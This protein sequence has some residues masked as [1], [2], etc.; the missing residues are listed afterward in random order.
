VEVTY[1]L[2]EIS[3]LAEL[4]VSTYATQKLF[5]LE[6]E[7]GAGKTTF[8]KQLCDK[9]GVVDNVSSPTYSVINKYL[10][11]DN[12]YIYHLD[13]FRL[14]NSQELINI[15]FEDILY[16]NSIILIEWPQLAYPLLD[17]ISYVKIFIEKTS[18]NSRKMITFIC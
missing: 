8:I 12:R 7:M 10:C 13:L 11:S 18:E 9:W 16:E 17:D 3:S 1:Q 5:C 15:G 4:F 2:D 6:G 14:K